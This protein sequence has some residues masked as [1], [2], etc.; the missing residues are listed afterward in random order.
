MSKGSKDKKEGVCDIDGPIRGG[1]NN[2]IRIPDVHDNQ[3]LYYKYN[4]ENSFNQ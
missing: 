3:P 1:V 4:R 2:P